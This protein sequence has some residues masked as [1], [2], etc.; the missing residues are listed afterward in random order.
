MHR[1]VAQGGLSPVAAVGLLDCDEMSRVS[2]FGRDVSKFGMSKGFQFLLGV[3][4]LT[5]T[6]TEVTSRAKQIRVVGKNVG[7][8]SRYDETV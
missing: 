5:E 4:D 1:Q 8:G 7:Q 2:K 6:E 3:G